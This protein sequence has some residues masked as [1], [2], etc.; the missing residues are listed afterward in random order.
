MQKKIAIITVNYNNSEDTLELLESFKKLDTTGFDVKMVVVDNGS[1]RQD[2]EKILKYIE[3][4]Q[5]PKVSKVSN[6]LSINGTLDTFPYSTDFLQTGDNF[7][8]TGGYNRGMEYGLAWGADYLLIINNDALFNSPNLL[9][10]LVQTAESEEKIGLV[11]PKIY[12]APGFEFYKDRYSQKDQG[13]VIWY[14]GGRFDW[15]N[16]MSSHRGIDEVDSGKY[17]LVEKVDFTTGCCLLIKREVLEKVGDFDNK[18]FAYFD[19]TDFSERVTRA[20]FKKFY[21]G[22]V[23]IFHKVSR[24]SGTGSAITDYFHTRN[25]LIFGFRYA[26]TRTKFAL[27]REA[28]FR[29][30]LMGRPMQRRGVIDF[31][32]GVT[33]AP[34][35]IIKPSQNPLFPYQLSLVSSNYNTADLLKNLISSILNSKS[36]FD[37]KSMEI[38][39]L[40]DCSPTDPTPEIKQFFP[41]IRFYKNEVNLG[42]TRSFNR[43]FKLS[44]GKNI[45]MLNSD[46]ELLEHSISELLK[47]EDKLNGEAVLG[48]RLYFPDMR[49]QDSVYFLPTPWGAIKEYFFNKTGSYFMYVPKPEVLTKVEG[50]VGACILIPR[51][52]F[53]KIGY[54]TEEVVSYFEDIEYLRRLKKNNIPAYFVPTAKFIHHHGAS[55]SKLGSKTL[56]IHQAS[57]KMYHGKWGYKMIY[58][59]LWLAQKLTRKKPPGSM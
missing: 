29:H 32:K 1:E 4:S 35:D 22:K 27:L 7:G 3:V 41:K 18:L 36:G 46:V 15:D 47:T 2:A 21:N 6:G 33:G 28:F 58:L 45:L 5:A 26:K 51:K 53:N 43:L 37:P 40:D 11:I 34:D 20:G 55:F 12:F 24:T 9:K 54:L 57:A 50:L 16:I 52:V 25:R 39:M 42:F 10:E 17:D 59:T 23:S 31:L 56:E 13:K 49:S 44:R 38:I 19:D 14:A 8:F 30:L 48:G